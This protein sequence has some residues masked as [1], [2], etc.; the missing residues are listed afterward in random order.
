MKTAPTEPPEFFFVTKYAL[1]KGI[2]R[3]KNND[4]VQIHDR[5]ISTRG[6]LAYR[7]DHGFTLYISSKDW[8]YSI[9]EARERAEEM[10]KAKIKSLKRQIDKL[11]SV[12]DWPPLTD[13]K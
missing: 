11:Q 1:S 5:S 4:R 8:F 2:Q 10:R 3:I 9:V 12:N 7:P 13:L 6:Y